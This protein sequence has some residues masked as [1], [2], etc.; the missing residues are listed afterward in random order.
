M[1]QPLIVNN[2]RAICEARRVLLRALRPTGRSKSYWQRAW[3]GSARWD[4]ARSH[5]SRR[6]WRRTPRAHRISRLAGTPAVYVPLSRGPGG[7]V[8]M[9]TSLLYHRRRAQGRCPTCGR[10]CD[11]LPYVEC[12]RCYTPR[13][14]LVGPYRHASDPDY[15]PTY[16]WHR[17][18]QRNPAVQVGCCGKF[19]MVTQ[20]PF[21][22]PCCGRVFG[23]LTAEE[24]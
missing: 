7:L 17:Q 16:H 14:P 3:R 15:W 2:I 24:S 5:A 11:Q 19:R 23:S 22:T 20:V 18:Q 21:R 13:E 4:I 9:A 1:L 10:A 12:T 8:A 6:S